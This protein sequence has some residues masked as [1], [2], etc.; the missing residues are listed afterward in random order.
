MR[1]TLVGSTTLARRDGPEGVEVP[2]RR[3]NVSVAAR[4]FRRPGLAIYFLPTIV[5]VGCVGGLAASAILASDAYDLREGRTVPGI[6]QVRDR[7]SGDVTVSFALGEREYQCDTSDVEG[8]PQISD[9]VLVR[10][11]TTDPEGNCAI[12]NAGQSY[13]PAGVAAGTGV[14]FGGAGGLL[15]RR[16]RRARRRQNVAADGWIHGW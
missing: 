4:L 9:Q 14:L 12:G 8:N 1:R 15:Y 3:P 11:A 10:Y 5:T 2:Q 13:E 7:D 6:V 16:G